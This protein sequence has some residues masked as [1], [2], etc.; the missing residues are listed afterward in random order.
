MKSVYEVIMNCNVFCCCFC[1]SS[2]LSISG[3]SV[4]AIRLGL[5]SLEDGRPRD[6]WRRDGGRRKGRMTETDVPE[7]DVPETD[8]SRWMSLKRVSPKR[9]KVMG[10]N[11]ETDVPETEGV[12]LLFFSNIVESFSGTYCLI[13]FEWC[14]WVQQCVGH[15]DDSSSVCGWVVGCV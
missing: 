14:V 6:G 1:M 7:T 8:V 11:T 4:C 2:C 15:V 13:I 12:L 3:I 5:R 10:M 9:R